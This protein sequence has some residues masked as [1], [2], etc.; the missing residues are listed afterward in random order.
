MGKAAQSHGQKRNERSEIGRKELSKRAVCDM[1]CKFEFNK[2]ETSGKFVRPTIGG[3]SDT[4]A[5]RS[6]MIPFPK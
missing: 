3:T 6:Q 5:S 1:G 2:K 4:M